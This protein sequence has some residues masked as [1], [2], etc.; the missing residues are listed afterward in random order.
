M[1]PIIYA[2]DEINDTIPEEV[3]HEAFSSRSLLNRRSVPTNLNS[4]IRDKVI[5]SRVMKA[6]QLQ[7]QKI[8]YID[9]NRMTILKQSENATIFRV[10][11]SDINNRTIVAPL[12]V[13]Y[14]K[15]NYRGSDM[16]FDTPIQTGFNKL[17]DGHRPVDDVS[18]AELHN[19]NNNTIMVENISQF[20]LLTLEAIVS[21]DP[22]YM[23]LPRGYWDSFAQLCLYATEAY[24]YRVLRIP[25]AQGK[26][27][28]GMEI[29]EFKSV[30]EEF[31]DS[32]KL[33]KE[34]LREFRKLDNI[35]DK[36]Q[37]INQL[38]LQA[39]KFY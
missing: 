20:N 34:K 7:S 3:I 23:D 1:T 28:G 37:K 31:R 33:Y 14:G 16:Q 17:I 27:E 12:S 8:E 38:R 15:D 13:S 25:L 35:G 21:H 22:E 18:N 2:L 11:S 6:L 29:G 10:N 5:C 26:I 36:R 30:V 32:Q 4:V 39:I 24:I 9:F 19:L